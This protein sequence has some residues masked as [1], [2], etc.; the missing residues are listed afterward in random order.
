MGHSDL[1]AE[2]RFGLFLPGRA[3]AALVE[4]M[5]RAIV[6]AV[7]TPA[8]SEAFTRLEFRPFTAES[9]AFAQMV[10]AERDR[11]GPIVRESG[12]QPED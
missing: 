9:Q 3:P 7:E 8:L 1:T 6:E 11:W 10:R 5:R 12:F 4:G 2:E